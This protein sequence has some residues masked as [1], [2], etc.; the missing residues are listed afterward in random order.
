MEYNKK[1]PT[2][3]E[4]M[5]HFER[6]ETQSKTKRGGVITHTGAT[7]LTQT[8]RTVWRQENTQGENQNKTSPNLV[9]EKPER[10][11]ASFHLH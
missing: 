11:R 7:N 3:G 8:V 6:T 10:A 2:H 9:A 1:Y 4:G 5:E